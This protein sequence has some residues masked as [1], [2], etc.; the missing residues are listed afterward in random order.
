MN[1]IAV[2]MPFTT[3]PIHVPFEARRSFLPFYFPDTIDNQRRG[4]IG[5]ERFAATL[6]NTLAIPCLL[7]VLICYP[8]IRE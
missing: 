3:S 7:P 8:H 5:T 2:A 4:S 1:G 6:P